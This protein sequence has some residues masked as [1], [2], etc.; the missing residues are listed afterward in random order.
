ML[1]NHNC[2]EYTEFDTMKIIMMISK[3]YDDPLRKQE[4]LKIMNSHYGIWLRENCK[5]KSF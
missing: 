4:I 3:E 1:E 5:K 2:I